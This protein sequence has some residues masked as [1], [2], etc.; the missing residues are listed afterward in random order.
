[1]VKKKRPGSLAYDPRK[2]DFY[3]S[4]LRD[5]FA[6]AALTGI[7]ASDKDRRVSDKGA[8]RMA[9]EMADAMLAEKRRTEEE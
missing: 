8:A 9:F 6:A 1:M 3:F 7:L 5:T 2:D 4:P